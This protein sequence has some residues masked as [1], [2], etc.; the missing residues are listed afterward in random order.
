MARRRKKDPKPSREEVILGRIQDP[1]C[2]AAHFYLCRG[3]DQGGWAWVGVM[4]GELLR[5]RG[6][7]PEKIEYRLD[8]YNSTGKSVV[9]RAGQYVRDYT[10]GET[11][12]VG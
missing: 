7:D 3:S 9:C 1:E 10:D 5:L 11:L 2:L 12:T 8:N 4:A 6:L